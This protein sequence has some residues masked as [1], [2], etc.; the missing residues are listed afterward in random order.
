MTGRPDTLLL[1]GHLRK[2]RAWPLLLAVGM[3]SAV[4]IM[5]R[6]Q[7]LL[8][9]FACLLSS[10]LGTHP[11]LEI[12]GIEPVPASRQPHLEPGVGHDLR[13]AKALLWVLQACSRLSLSLDL[14][15]STQ[16]A[17]VLKICHA[18]C[19]AISSQGPA[20]MQNLRE[21]LHQRK[22]MH[23]IGASGHDAR[24]QAQAQ[25]ATARPHLQDEVAQEV[26]ALGRHSRAVGHVVVARQRPLHD[27]RRGQ[28]VT[29]LAVCVSICALFDAREASG[30]PHELSA[31]PQQCMAQQ[32]LCCSGAGCPPRVL[33]VCQ[34]Q[35]CLQ[36]QTEL[37]CM[38]G[39]EPCLE[40]EQGYHQTAAL[41]PGRVP[42]ALKGV[43]AEEQHVQ[44]HAA[45]PGVGLLA[46]IS[47]LC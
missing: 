40:A 11:V 22:P 17:G 30:H 2:L 13:C 41:S 1:L 6:Q 5:S 28:D 18:P 25:A 23:S 38:H 26:A 16:G 43:L 31:E 45:G 7:D 44:Q 47:P 46:I 3:V 21:G 8:A 34:Q 29:V 32:P 33:L 42:C 9:C 12:D 24:Q 4:G 19:K 36:H 27:L 14:F 20:G 35:V 37:G 39:L 10:L 15:A